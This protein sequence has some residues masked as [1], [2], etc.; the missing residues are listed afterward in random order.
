MGLLDGPLA[1][2]S[3]WTRTRLLAHGLTS[4]ALAPLLPA[5]RRRITARYLDDPLIAL[6]SRTCH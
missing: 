3:R 4:R 2:M 1:E 5:R 6:A